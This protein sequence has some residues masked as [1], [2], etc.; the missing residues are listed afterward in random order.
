MYQSYSYYYSCLQ[1]VFWVS[2]PVGGAADICK[3]KPEINKVLPH[4]KHMQPVY[5]G[6]VTELNTSSIFMW[7]LLRRSKEIR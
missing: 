3:T 4:V 1:G 2:W 5:C 6:F 7:K